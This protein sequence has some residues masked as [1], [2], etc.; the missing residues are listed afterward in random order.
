MSDGTQ[1]RAM[2]RRLLLQDI[3]SDILRYVHA[4][5][6]SAARGIAV[7]IDNEWNLGSSGE[8]ADIRV[9]PIGTPPYFVE[10]KAGY[11]DAEVVRRLAL[12]YG[13]DNAR[14]GDATKVVVV[15]DMRRRGERDRLVADI[16]AAVTPSLAIEIWDEAQIDAYSRRLFDSPVEDLSDEVGLVRL[17]RG[18]NAAQARLAF[19]TGSSDPDGVLRQSLVWHFGAWR[20]KEL[21]ESHEA[22]TGPPSD[23]RL[24]PAGHYERAIV[25]M[26]DISSFSS[27]VRDTPDE[28]ITRASLTAFYSKAR[29]QVLDAGGMFYQFVGDEVS[30]VF[31]VPD[32]RPG[33]AHEAMRTARALLEIT[34]SV[35]THWQRRIDRVQAHCAAHI[36]MAMGDLDLVAQRPFDGARLGAFGDCL[37]IAARLQ[38]TAAPN[39]IVISNVLRQE[40]SDGTYRCEERPEIEIKNL[41]TVRSWR[42]VPQ[43]LVENS[44]M[45]IAELVET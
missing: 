16:R 24:V 5:E 30:A 29:G 37:N 6:R 40:L 33:Y 25:V 41:G 23:E 18:I 31:G 34:R 14:S 42:V 35:T 22:R 10:I 27:F 32:Q 9:R 26:A 21:R 36:G 19:G 7:R 39:E 20:L 43:S 13:H 44:P 1:A 11:T 12:K 38:H 28:E 3:C 15:L 4:A 2:N 45:R 8:F 17:R